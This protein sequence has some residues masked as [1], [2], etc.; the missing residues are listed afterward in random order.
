MI[1]YAGDFTYHGDMDEVQKFLQWYGEQDAKHKLLICGNHEVWISQQG[2][3]LKQLCQ[4]EGI[5]LLHNSHTIIEGLTIFGSPYSKKFGRWAYM[6][7]ETDLADIYDTIL[8]D[9]DIIISHGPAYKQL[10]FCPG[11][12]VGSTA[13]AHRIGELKNLKLVVTGHIH[14]S[15]GTMI[16]DG[17]LTVNAAICGIPYS[18][19]IY[20]PITVE[21]DK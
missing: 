2:D 12:H 5:Q 20:N 4:N 13:L 11:G 1:I 9:T 3:L 14:E 21:I 10:D 19:I 17:V 16:K 18:D 15:R 7:D 8:P 6:A